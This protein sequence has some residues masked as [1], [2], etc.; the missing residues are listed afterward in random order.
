MKTRA[1]KSFFFLAY[2]GKFAV[3][4]VSHN[5]GHEVSRG[6]WPSEHIEIGHHASIPM[7]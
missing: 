5:I 2:M 4:N 1:V 3:S 6:F 7:L